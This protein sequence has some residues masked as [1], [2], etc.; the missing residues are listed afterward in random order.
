MQTLLPEQRR[1]AGLMLVV[2]GILC[3]IAAAG[4]TAL[5]GNARADAASRFTEA[6]ASCKG[7]LQALGGRVEE[8]PGR[9]I[10]LK[11]NIEQAPVRLGEASVAAV[12]CPGWRLK[13]SCIGSDCPE[14]N[15]MRIVLEPINE[16]VE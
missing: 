2:F 4:I 8:I 6:Q 7:R 13:T 15:S 16:P 9:L 11:D 5:I 12:L 10:W 14:A 3:I 1:F